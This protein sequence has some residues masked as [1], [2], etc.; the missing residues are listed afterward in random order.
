[1]NVMPISYIMVAMSIIKYPTKIRS[2]SASSNITNHAW[3]GMSLEKDINDS[4]IYYRNRD[5]AIIYKKPTPVQVV[6]VDYPQRNKA[7][8][9]EAYYKIPSTTD[10]NGIY[11]GKYIDFEAKETKN[12]TSFPLS[13]IHA[14]Q[15]EHLERIINHG[16]IGFFIIR[17]S[18]HGITF[19]VPAMELIDHM[20]S[21]QRQSIPFSWFECHAYVIKEGLCPRLAYLSIIDKLYFKEDPLCQNKQNVK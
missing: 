15:I 9:T 7:K 4:N 6:Q 13:M 20:R 3:R 18:S 2:N 17:F 19:L 1:M 5:I 12:K 8:I 10:Y 21:I 16:G 14:H 11:K